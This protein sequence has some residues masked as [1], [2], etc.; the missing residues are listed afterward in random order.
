MATEGRLNICW[1]Q[2][3]LCIRN[4]PFPAPRSTKAAHALLINCLNTM[5][6][7]PIFTL[8]A[9]A[10]SFLQN[11][12]HSQLPCLIWVWTWQSHLQDIALENILV[13]FKAYL[14]LNVVLGVF[15]VAACS[16]TSC[17]APIVFYPGTYQIWS[18]WCRVASYCRGN[19][20]KPDS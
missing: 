19:Y 10:S 17:P 9:K 11:K 18:M 1:R 7:F 20:W 5:T 2:G 15:S 6:G 12:N 4:W 16:I 3:I 14:K 13:L 8:I